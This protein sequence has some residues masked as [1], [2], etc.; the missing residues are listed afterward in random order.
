MEDLY[1]KAGD[2]IRKNLER[3]AESITD[4]HTS[5]LEDKSL[6]TLQHDLELYYR[7]VLFNLSFL[8]E[9]ISFSEPVIYDNALDW[10]K[11]YLTKNNIT[12]QSIISVQDI[13]KKFYQKEAPPDIKKIITDHIENSLK[14]FQKAI[15]QESTKLNK[16]SKYYKESLSY[17]NY[18]LNAEKESAY[19]LIM[20]LLDK[21]T[22]I[23]DI[24]LQI[25]EPVQKELGVLWQKGKITV[26]QEHYSTA[27]T[28]MIMSSFYEY[29]FEVEKSNNIFVGACTRGELHEIGLL[30]ISDLLELNGWNTYYL[31]ANVPGDSIVDILVEKE[32]D[33]IGLSA[34]MS[35]NLSEA[36]KIIELIKSSKE[37]KDL[38]IIV[39]GNAFNDSEKIWKKTGADYFAIGAEEAVSLI[40]KML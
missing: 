17:L 14:I 22:S 8:A 32:A 30:M 38:K 6:K 21:G 24:Y 25:F 4:L 36:R 23:K 28:Q 20:G 29:L 7:G 16:E 34:T 5:L 11:K 2:Y 9:S 15:A 27:V 40:C 39:G 1:I 31:G 13:I 18:L 3:H 26:A 37:C 10:G 19:K 12:L 35:Y 33:V